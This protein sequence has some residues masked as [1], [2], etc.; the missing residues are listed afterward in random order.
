MNHIGP[1][2]FD[3]AVVIISITYC[4]SGLM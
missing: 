3:S 2:V 4:R 1:N